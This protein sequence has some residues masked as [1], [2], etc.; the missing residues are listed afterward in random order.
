MPAISLL[1]KNVTKLLHQPGVNCFPFLWTFMGNRGDGEKSYSTAKNLHISSIKKISINKSFAVKKFNSCPIKQQFSSNHPRQ[2]SFVAAVNSVVSYLN[3]RFYVHT[4]HANLTNQC[5]LN[6]FFSMTKAWMIEAL[7]SKISISSLPPMLLRK[8]YFY[9]CLFS[10][11]S[12]CFFYYKLYKIS[13][14]STPIGILWLWE[15]Q[16]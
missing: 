4:S 15:N 3:F 6:I 16:I 7:P 2:S 12:L 5:L 13:T 11:F 10:S 14:D 9:R 1:T 8:L